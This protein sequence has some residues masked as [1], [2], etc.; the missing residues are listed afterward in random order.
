METIGNVR[1][2]FILLALIDCISLLVVAV[3]LLFGLAQPFGSVVKVVL[4]DSPTKAN[5]F[6]F[7]VQ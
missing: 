6:D 5:F 2:T 4:I 3:D 1:N 7:H